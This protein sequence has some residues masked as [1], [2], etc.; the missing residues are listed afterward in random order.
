MSEYMAAQTDLQVR[1]GPLSAPSTASA[2]SV[3][4]RIRVEELRRQVSEGTYK[5]HP[6]RLA[7]KILVKALR[8]Q[9]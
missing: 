3:S 8:D 6:Q 9:S 2:E 7:L 5:V 4:R 1:K